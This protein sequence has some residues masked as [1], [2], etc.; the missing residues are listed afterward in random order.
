MKTKTV[1]LRTALALLS[2]GVL[3]CLVPVNAVQ[4][5]NERGRRE[6]DREQR[7]GDRGDRDRERGNR[8]GQRGSSRGGGLAGLL[9]QDPIRQELKITEEQS[10]KIQELVEQARPNPSMIAELKSKSSEER[11]K[12]FEQLRKRAEEGV[13]QVLNE[14]QFSRLQQLVLQDELAAEFKLTDTQKEQIGQLNGQR[15]EAVRNAFRN[16]LSDEERGRLSAEWNEKILAVFTPEQ[17]QLWQVKTGSAVAAKPTSVATAQAAPA[18]ETPQPTKPAPAGTPG[19]TTVTSE[20]ADVP[21]EVAA[22]FGASASAQKQ[23]GR[24]ERVG[25]SRVGGSEMISFTFQNAPWTEVLK[26]FAETAELTLHLKDVPPGTFNYIDKGLYTPAEAL[27]ILNGYLLQESHILV[28]RD[29]FLVVINLNNPVPPNLIPKISP[30]ELSERGRNELL[31]VRFRLKDGIDVEEVSLDVEG[32]LGPQGKSVALVNLNS[33]S[34]T[35]IGSNLM[36]ID[37]MIIDS[38]EKVDP[39]TTV[40]KAFKLKFISAY[41]AETIVVAQLGLDTGV[42]NVSQS[43]SSGSSS[44]GSSRLDQLR[45]RFGGMSS[46]FGGSGGGRPGGFPGFG[47][48]SRSGGDSGRSSGGGGDRRSQRGASG[49][50][51]SSSTAE[52]ARVT[53]EPRTNSLLVSAPS[54]SMKNVEELILAIDVPEDKTASQL[55]GFENR[56]SREPY[57]K[58]YK[59][60]KADTLEV[61]KTLTAIMPDVV[62]NEDGRGRTIHIMATPDQ[63]IEVAKLINELD[64]GGASS[65]QVAVISLYRMDPM[66]ASAILNALYINETSNPPTIEADPYSRRLLV[67]ASSS[68]IT[69]IR[70]V[71]LDY[72]ESGNGTLTGNAGPRMPVR[73]IPLGGRDPEKLA[74]MLQQIL[75]GSGQIENTI[76]VVVPA[77][78]SDAVRQQV[79]SS[80]D[81]RR[82]LEPTRQ[83]RPRRPQQ[84]PQADP[85][86][87]P[88]KAARIQN[89][90]AVSLVSFQSEES[91]NAESDK[92]A[93]G[94]ISSSE[95]P[96]AHVQTKKTGAAYEETPEDLK[97]KTSD[98]KPEIVISI[99]GGNL[100]ISS[101][102]LDALDEVER[103]ID[104]YLQSTPQESTWTVFYLRSADAV[105]TASMLQQLLPDSS[106]DSSA[107]TQQQPFNPF[108]RFFGGGNSRQAPSRPTTSLSSLQELQIIA[109]ERSN[110]LFVSGP[111]EKVKDVE[112]LLRV[113]DADELPESL[114]DRA[115][116]IIPV[117]YADVNEVAEI[118]K[119]VYQEEMGQGSSSSANRG[120]QQS[121]SPFGRGGFGGGSTRG[122]GQSSKP[123]KLTVGVDTNTSQLIVSC[124]ESLYRQIETLVASLDESAYDAKRTVRVMTLDHADSA[125]VQQAVT[126][127]IPSVKVSTSSTSSSSSSSNRS[128]SSNNSNANADR[129]RMER[130]QR[131]RQMF[132]GGGPGGGGP[133][134]G[135]RFGGGG[136]RFGGGGT[137]GGRGGRS[138]GGSPGGGRR[139]R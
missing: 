61:T 88:Q 11:L 123:I 23:Q 36:Q 126:S 119:S 76:R 37:R 81:Q 32:L 112:R 40:F 116:K 125:L 8:G 83:E 87:K 113:L 47:G 118:V 120:S 2:L 138:G 79:P 52:T 100:V 98:A 51:S 124:S 3:V 25:T 82:A 129:E 45:S 128:S 27:D 62:V 122:S 85:E 101:T 66:Q 6:G 127:L 26:M 42:K 10:Q 12:F 17:K 59:V 30:V 20:G 33:I 1:S 43:G 9:S 41:D 48:T 38:T 49:S 58:V 16:R 22:S 39:N 111:A 55:S 54:K 64:G 70:K 69:D 89:G 104:M 35:D 99:S 103:T 21:K 139:G 134:G 94:E 136:S 97:K 133:G 67:R 78:E 7:R 56:R 96:A 34:V 132:S 65:Q 14:D 106:L 46:R 121:S 137:P 29:Q 68:Q 93:T 102:D 15:G 105:E 63:H 135:S 90:Q 24:R 57:L 13:K 95:Q 130:I 75:Q 53:A 74:R 4:A 108:S 86:K 80:G 110:A 28:R 71:L 73:S 117:E 84:R 60:S 5:Q 50:S 44:S 72:G 91:G 107:T 114:R 31:E 92:K 115:P 109:E 19:A 131:F 18:T 77:K